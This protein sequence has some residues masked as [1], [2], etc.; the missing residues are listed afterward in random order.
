VGDY[1]IAACFFWAQ[2]SLKAYYVTNW[3]LFIKVLIINLLHRSVSALVWD[4]LEGSFGIFGLR[5]SL[6]G[7]PN[8]HESE[9]MV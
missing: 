7:M 4:G 9:G 6:V 1:L 5:A 8:V 3:P 2:L